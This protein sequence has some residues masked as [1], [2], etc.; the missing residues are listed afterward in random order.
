MTNLLYHRLLGIE[1]VRG[2]T[3]V[4]SDIATLLLGPI[5]AVFITVLVI[6]S[7]TSGINGNTMSASRIYYAMAKDGLLFKWMDFIHPQFRT[8]SRAIVLHCFWAAMLLLIK[9]NFETIITGQVFTN[10]FFYALACLAFFKLR[11]KQ[12]GEKKA[13]RVPL[14]P[15]LPIFYFLA[16]VGLLIFRLIFEFEKSLLDIGL[17]VS[18]IPLYFFWQKNDRDLGGTKDKS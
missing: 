5:G 12:I 11:Q 7:T 1:G 16:I 4:A 10:L 9:G 3:V 15:V 2:S 18:G 14:Y 6:I 8:P 17:V 13:F